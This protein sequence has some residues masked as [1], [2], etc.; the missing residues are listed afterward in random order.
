MEQMSSVLGKLAISLHCFAKKLIRHILSHGFHYDHYDPGKPAWN[1]EPSDV[2]MDGNR[3]MV[4]NVKFIMEKL[5]NHKHTVE[6]NMIKK[7]LKRT[8]LPELWDQLEKLMIGSS[9]DEP[10]ERLDV[11]NQSNL[12]TEA[13]KESINHDDVTQFVLKITSTKKKK[14]KARDEKYYQNRKKNKWRKI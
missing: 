1:G 5:K 9:E 4:E 7:Y 11:K 3:E 8:N 13:S 2:I 10:V 6:R 12:N 14:T